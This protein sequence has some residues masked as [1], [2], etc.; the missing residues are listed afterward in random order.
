MISDVGALVAAEAAVPAGADWLNSYHRYDDTVAHFTNLVSQ[1]PSIASTFSIGQSY[2]GRAL[3]TVRISSGAHNYDSASGLAQ[4]NGKPGFWMNALIHAREWVT[5]GSINWMVNHVLTSYDSDSQIQHIVDNFD[6]YFLLIANPDG[7][8]YTHTNNRMWRKTRMPHSSSSCKGT[9][10]NR[11]FDHHWSEVGTSTNPCSDI[12]HGE[13]APNQPE[14]K[15]MQDFITFHGGF[16]IFIDSHSYSQMWLSPWGYT[17]DHPPDYDEHMAVQGAAVAALQA[18]H[19]TVYTYGPSGITIYPTSGTTDDWAY[20][21]AGIVNSYCTE[22]RDTGQYGFVLPPAQIVPNAE[23]FW[24]GL[25]TIF[26]HVGGPLGPTV[27]PTEAPTMAPTISAAPTTEAFGSQVDIKVNIVT[28][29]Y[30][31]ETGW[32]LMDGDTLLLQK[33]SGSYGNNQQYVETVRV[34][35]SA[36]GASRYTFTITDTYGDGICCGYGQGSYSIISDEA[37]VTP[38][39]SGGQFTNEVTAQFDVVIDEGE[40]PTAAP[41]AAPVDPIEACNQN[42]KKCIELP[43]AQFQVGEAIELS[44]K[45]ASNT[46][47]SW[48]V[49]ITNEDK[50]PKKKKVQLFLHTCGEGKGGCGDADPQKSGTVT[51]DGNDPEEGGKNEFPLVAG[52]YDAHLANKGKSKSGGLTFTVVDPSRRH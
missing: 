6:L 33:P 32:S 44:W 10:P 45:G 12:F 4:S 22:A 17:N 40:A 42:G 11:N 30:G 23:E 37:T 8:E 49:A 27:S 14:V 1:Y 9:D 5:G 48:K 34:Y 24:A 25:L 43:K 39:V 38:A 47:D 13:A 28:D 41:T 3:F 19:G 31:S 20:G 18:V 21:V 52:I 51:V 36:A 35:P 29:N 2:E 16:E 26:A 7:Y 46:K 15:A 50:P